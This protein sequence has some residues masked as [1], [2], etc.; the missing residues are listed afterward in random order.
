[1]KKSNI[2]K[3]LPLLFLSWKIYKN[4]RRPDI[5][6]AKLFQYEVNT[7]DSELCPFET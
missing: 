4:I 5:S 3:P 2:G 6:K 1:M 7:F